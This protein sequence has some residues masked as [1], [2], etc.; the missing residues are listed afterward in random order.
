MLDVD[1]GTYPYTTSSHVIA[2]GCA[3]GAGFPPGYLKDIV[4]IMKAYTTRVGEGPMPT[5]LIDDVGKHLQN[6]GHEFGTTTSRPR[7][8]GWLDLVVVKHS[9]ML[10]GINKLAVTKLDVLS[11]LK[12]IK[13]C[14]GYR[15]NG[16]I[17]DKFP[18]TIEDVESCEPVY[19]EFH[20]W[21]DFDVP[22]TFND[23]PE[24]AQK[25]LKFIESYL[26]VN[27]AVVS[28]GP[29]RNETLML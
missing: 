25:Y 6:K 27:I 23:I 28:T 13:I 17:I 5:E 19:R 24:Q 14:T 18:S 12:T 2:G 4:G 21:D 16:K 10:S 22:K 9:C 26:N 15:L 20:G 3:I 7:R 8:C 11:G 1:Y 29:E